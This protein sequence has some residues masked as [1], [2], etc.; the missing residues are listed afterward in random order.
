VT[1]LTLD[2]LDPTREPGHLGRVGHYAVTEVIGH[3]GMGVVLR[4][5]ASRSGTCG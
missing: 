2:F 5:V 4:A 1:A 3:G